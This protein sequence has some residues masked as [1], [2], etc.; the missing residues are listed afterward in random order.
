MMNYTPH[1]GAKVADILSLENIRRQLIRLEDT[2]IFCASCFLV[3][4]TG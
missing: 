1:A 2:I 3:E 4:L